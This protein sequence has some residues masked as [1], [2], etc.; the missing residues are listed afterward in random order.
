MK[1]LF[2]IILCIALAIMPVCTVF[3]EDT[4]PIPDDI[5]ALLEQNPAQTVMDKQRVM[6]A[7]PRP[8]NITAQMAETAVTWMT[9]QVGNAAGQWN[10][11]CL[12]MV[13]YA[14]QEVDIFQGGYSTGPIAAEV[15]RG[16]GQLHEGD[17]NAPRGT[18]IMFGA[19]SNVSYDPYGYGH[20]AMSIGDGKVVHSY[21]GTIRI[22]YIST[23]VSHGYPYLGWGVWH[24]ENGNTMDAT[25]TSPDE[26][27]VAK[28]RLFIQ[29][30]YDKV[31]AR[32]PSASEVAYYVTAIANG[33]SASQIAA[34]FIASPEFIARN[35]SDDEAVGVLY[36]TLLDRAPSPKEVEYYTSQLAQGTRRNRILLNF[37]ESQEFARVCAEYGMTGGSVS[38]SDAADQNDGVSRF[39]FRL[40]AQTLNRKPDE[41]GWNFQA[42][43]ILQKH[44]TPE[45]TAENFVFSPEFTAK[46]LSDDDFVKMLYRTFFGREGNA[47]TEVR[48]HTARLQ[49]G[50]PRSEV[51]R[52]FS[53][54]HEFKKIIDTFGI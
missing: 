11:K 42:N 33:T 43:G 53:R 31:F 9:N 49:S 3:A 44:S 14:F 38:F 8:V 19:C 24:A 12:Q 45:Q 6:L 35:Y 17:M 48:Y 2:A 16:S 29:R 4:T 54:S 41:S 40:Y 27:Q 25:P 28:Q 34:N 7:S 26:A 21:A 22:D 30:L 51:L 18:L 13:R 39:V 5:F 15:L 32:V 20:A 37:C 23:V 10:G 46:N 47:A 52:G 50:V 1:R 36:T